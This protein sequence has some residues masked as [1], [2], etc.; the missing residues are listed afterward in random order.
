MATHSS[1]LAW[2]PWGLGEG[3]Q[4][5]ELCGMLATEPLTPDLSCFEL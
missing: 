5:Q 1:S 3:V 2:V 4:E